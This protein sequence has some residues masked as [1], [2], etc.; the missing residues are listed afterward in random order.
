[1]KKYI[2]VSMADFLKM[3]LKDYHLS[4]YKLAKDIG[5]PVSRIQDILHNRR[6]M[7]I[8]TSMRL[9]KYFGVDGTFFF[10]VQL[11]LDYTA[12]MIEMKKELDKIESI[13]KKKSKSLE[14]KEKELL[15]SLEEITPIVS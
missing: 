7:S 8:D 6:K 2:E 12:A 1:M 11:D 9:G 3:Y 14:D 15:K 5:V 4:A 10:R 13:K